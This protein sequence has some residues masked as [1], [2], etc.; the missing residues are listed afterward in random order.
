MYI[1]LLP[2]IVFD[3]TKSYGTV[4]QFA[5]ALSLLAAA[6]QS[7]AALLDRC[8]KRKNEHRLRDKG[9]EIVIH[10]DDAET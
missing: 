7:V 1:D 5:G 8:E 9:F 4:I 2:G 6:I 10:A 3:W